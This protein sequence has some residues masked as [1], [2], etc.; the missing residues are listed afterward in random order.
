MVSGWKERKDSFQPC[1]TR[2]WPDGSWGQRSPRRKSCSRWE[3]PELCFAPLPGCPCQCTRSVPQAPSALSRLKH[4]RDCLV[5]LKLPSV[6]LWVLSTFDRC[7]RRSEVVQVMEEDLVTVGV[8]WDARNVAVGFAADPFGRM[9]LLKKLEGEKKVWVAADRKKS[10]HL[11]WNYGIL[12][13]SFKTFKFI[14]F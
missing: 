2:N 8:G 13:C 5:G 9:G 14:E 4:R 10:Y 7:K 3:G 12:W 11:I 1:R 6:S